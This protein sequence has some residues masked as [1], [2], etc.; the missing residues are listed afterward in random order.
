MENSPFP[1]LWRGVSDLHS[2]F[3]EVPCAR[4]RAR[5]AV[6]LHRARSEAVVSPPGRL[7]QLGH[8][9]KKIKTPKSPGLS[10]FSNYGNML[11]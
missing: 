8:R 4:A 2:G 10:S 5:S 11:G 6:Q 9:S 1:F 7:N 3:P